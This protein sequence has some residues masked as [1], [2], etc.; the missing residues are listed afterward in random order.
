VYYGEGTLKLGFAQ[1]RHPYNRE[2]VSFLE[3]EKMD[4][5]FQ[6]LRLSI[7]HKDFY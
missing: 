6:L 2:E 7:D 4:L 3:P 5:K 1:S